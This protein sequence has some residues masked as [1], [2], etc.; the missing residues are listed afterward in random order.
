MQRLR[1]PRRSFRITAIASGKED[2]V[3][4][5]D[6][7]DVGVTKQFLYRE[8]QNGLQGKVTPNCRQHCSGCGVRT[9][10]DSGVCYEVKAE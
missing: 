3:F 5:W 4:P 9:L 10:A 2:E 8:Y 6:H 7:I 1:K